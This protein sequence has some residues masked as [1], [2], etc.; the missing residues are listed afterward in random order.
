MVQNP[1]TARR[2]TAVTSDEQERSAAEPKTAADDGSDRPGYLVLSCMDYRHMNDIVRALEKKFECKD[3]NYDHLVLA[4]ASLGVV[5]ATYPEWGKTF[6]QHLGIALELHPTIHT[7]IL[8]EHQDCG[9]YKKFFSAKYD[10][11]LHGA[12]SA[13]LAA[14]IQKAF[15]RLGVLRMIMRPDT[16]GTSWKLEQL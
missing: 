16:S 15:A 8:L 10:D 14:Q 7:V 5:Q 11:A 6:W 4:G 13:V 2:S 3:D 9:A 1:A 12:T